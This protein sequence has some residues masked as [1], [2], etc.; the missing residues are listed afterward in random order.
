MFPGCCE[1]SGNIFRMIGLINGTGNR[2]LFIWIFD[3]YPR[4]KVDFHRNDKLFVKVK[5]RPSVRSFS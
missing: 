2:T 1:T 5:E 4:L 3:R